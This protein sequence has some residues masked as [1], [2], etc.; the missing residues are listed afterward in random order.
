MEGTV[1]LS[2]HTYYEKYCKGIM[3][4]KDLE[5]IV[6]NYIL[7]EPHRFSL[8]RWTQDDLFDF[9]CWAYPRLGRS[10]DRYKDKGATFDAYINSMIRLAHKEFRFRRKDKKVMEYSWWNAN[11]KD[12]YVANNEPDYANFEIENSIDS[13]IKNQRQVLFLLLKCY[14][15]LSEDFI[16]KIAPALDVDKQELI[17]LIDNLH[18]LR[19]H[20]E[21]EF[22]ILRERINSQFFR[23]ICFESRM[24]AAAEGSAHY[25]RMKKCWEKS[26]VR[27]R[28]M[29]KRLSN[30]RLN[31]SN[32]QLAKL[33][34]I[35]KGTIDSSLHA[36]KERSGFQ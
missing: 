6:F 11:A 32:S 35:P 7:K 25:E 16:D 23:C 21:D 20:Q 5:G 31:A 14:Y 1:S 18:K 36:L 17:T 34:D 26:R 29:R 4:K 9:L 2:L 13:P 30:M 24:R 10:I 3:K 27:L 8:D 19:K 12:S 28:S 33:L 15:F 22:N